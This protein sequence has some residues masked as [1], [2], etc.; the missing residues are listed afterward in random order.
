[1]DATSVEASPVVR[2]SA[3]DVRVLYYGD[4]E[5]AVESADGAAHRLRI[6]VQA[7][8]G[9]QAPDPAQV[10]VPAAGRVAATVRVWR[11]SAPRGGRQPLLVVAEPLDTAAPAVSQQVFAEILPDPAWMPRLRRPLGV[12]ALLLMAAAALLEVRRGRR[13]ATRP[14]PG[15]QK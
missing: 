7:P 12:L 9:L 11:S 4:V 1:V 8:A 6:R 10:D 3:R 14:G 15:N 13:T 5:V 2:V